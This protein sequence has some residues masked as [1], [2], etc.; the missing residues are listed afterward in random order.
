M[1]KIYFHDFQAKRARVA[2]EKNM[3][4][5]RKHNEEA[6]NGKHTF[7]LRANSMTDFTQEGMHTLKYHHSL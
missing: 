4:L 2:F 3:E 5:I 7:E 6:R 1:N